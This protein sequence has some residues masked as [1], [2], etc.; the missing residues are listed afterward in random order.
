MKRAGL[1]HALLCQFASKDDLA[2]ETTSECS[3]THCAG[4]ADGKS[5][6]SFAELVRGYLSPGHRDDPGTVV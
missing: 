4:A 3:R 1:T 6:P 2:A 5:N